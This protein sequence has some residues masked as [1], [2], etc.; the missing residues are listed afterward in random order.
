M[1]Q[2]PRTINNWSKLQYLISEVN[3]ALDNGENF[4]VS[5]AFYSPWDSPSKKVKDVD[6]RVNLFEV[7]EAYHIIQDSFPD[8]KMPTLNYVPTL[9]TFRGGLKGD[10]GYTFSISVNDNPT[11]IHR[12]LGFA[13]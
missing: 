3:E 8:A 4:C 6:V 7:P 12:E 13:G 2:L 9:V 10:E 5:V 11:A 1:K